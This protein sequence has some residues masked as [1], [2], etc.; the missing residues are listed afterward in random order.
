MNS[1]SVDL[2][3]LQSAKMAMFKRISELG[4]LVE[5]I[6]ITPPR[7][8]DIYNFYMFDKGQERRL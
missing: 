4:E 8:D 1:K 2:E 5:D 6:E 3:C 7:L